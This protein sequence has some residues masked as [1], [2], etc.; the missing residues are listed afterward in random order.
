MTHRHCSMLHVL[1]GEQLIFGNFFC[2]KYLSLCNSRGNWESNTAAQPLCIAIPTTI[3]RLANCFISLIT[4]LQWFCSFFLVVASISTLQII[5]DY[6]VQEIDPIGEA[7]DGV[8]LIKLNIFANKPKPCILVSFA[9]QLQKNWKQVNFSSLSF[10]T[11]ESSYEPVEDAF[12]SC[13][14][15]DAQSASFIKILHTILL[16]ILYNPFYS[17]HPLMAVSFLSSSARKGRIWKQNCDCIHDR[18]FE[19]KKTNSYVSQCQFRHFR[20]LWQ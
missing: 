6:D 11:V 10:P 12:P 15:C 9:M 14:L 5:P 2:V 17:S 1:C 7:H 8:E 16:T 18:W 4:I 19:N 3:T 13:Q 20:F